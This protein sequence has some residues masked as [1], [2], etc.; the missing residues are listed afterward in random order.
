[1]TEVVIVPH[2]ER[3]EAAQLAGIAAD[4][5]AARG[6]RA[7]LLRRDAELL[8]LPALGA[9]LDPSTAGLALSLGGDGSVLRTVLLLGGAAVPVIAVNVGTLAYLTEV[10]PSSLTQALER[11]FDGE[12]TIERR[13]LLDVAVRRRSGDGSRDSWRALN[14]AVLER[15]EAG[16]TVRLLVRI[17]DAPFMS[18]AADGMIIA[19]PTGST[20]YNLSAGG[21]IVQPNVDAMIIT[22]IA[23]HTLTNRPIV[24]PG[25]STVRIQ[26][27]ME[28]RDEIVFTL[29]GQSTF[30]IHAGD[31]ISISRAP[32]RCT[33]RASDSNCSTPVVRRSNSTSAGSIPGTSVETRSGTVSSCMRISS[34]SL[35]PLK[36]GRPAS[37]S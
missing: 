18:Y 27:T 32:R 29:D 1:M 2:Q 23:P 20:A 10:E 8:G 5:L 33:A 4:W 6:H 25:T 9:D 31:E 35:P 34:Y 37:I 14:E 26:P 11:Y 12:C 24:I 7:Y 19:T 28:A 17:D 30:P 15:E 36:G 22:P 21:P 3:A 16:H 13:M